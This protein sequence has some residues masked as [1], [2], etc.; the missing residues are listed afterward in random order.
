MLKNKRSKMENEKILR[1]TWIAI[2]WTTSSTVTSDKRMKANFFFFLRL[3]FFQFDFTKDY[4][5]IFCLF[6]SSS[7]GAWLKITFPSKTR[8]RYFP[9]LFWSVNINITR[10]QR[11]R[12]PQRLNRMFGIFRNEFS[13]TKRLISTQL[14]GEW[15]QHYLKRSF[16]LI[17]FLRSFFLGSVSQQAFAAVKKLK[18]FP[19]LDSQW[20]F[21]NRKTAW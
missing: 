7:W 18:I 3:L 15:L 4:F 17:F 1:S 11:S 2:K 6:S 5:E 14:E 13:V 8:Q 19:S 9:A 21:K 10:Q 16:P 12:E 20:N